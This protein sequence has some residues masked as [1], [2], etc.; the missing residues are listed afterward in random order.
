MDQKTPAT[1]LEF[2]TKS[3]LSNEPAAIHALEE[4]PR[5]MFVQ[6]LTAAFLG[7]HK[8]VLKAMVRNWPFPCLH[9]G[10]LRVQE[11]QYDNLEAMIDGLQILPAQFSSFSGP[12]LRI[13]DL[14]QDP[15]CRTTCSE[16]RTTFPYCFRSCVHSPHSIMK[17]E[18]AQHRV[19]CPGNVNSESEPQSSRKSMELLVDVSLDGTW[20]TARFLS[21]LRSKVEQSFGT[22]HLCC[23]YMQ[24]D[25]MPVREY[26][27]QFLD[28]GCIDHLEV[29][30][31][32]LNEAT[33]LLAQMTHLHR[34]SMS[35]IPFTSFMRRSFGTF[36]AHLV[37]MDTLQEIS[38]SYCHTHRLHK[39]LRCLPP[40]LDAL[41]LSFCGLS[42]RDI[43]ALSQSPAAPHLRL[44]SLCNNEISWEH[45]EAFQTLLA[46]VSGTLQHLEIDNCL[47]TDSTLTAVIPAL[48]H[49]SHL[50]VF[51]FTSNPITMRALTSLLQHLTNLTELKRVIYP[52]PVH[53][54]E[55][56][57]DPGSLNRLKLSEVQAQLKAMLQVV[58]RNDMHWTTSP[59]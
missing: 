37:Q 13:L 6:F 2:A 36:L 29:D 49:C 12:K 9:V 24:I 32:Y 45:S 42:N 22:L 38:L 27:L 23:R 34:L 33:P 31:I 3:L 28:M 20:R 55:R 35:H 30:E 52:V 21:L 53:C 17:I 18:E 50:R 5:D 11:S 15:G 14:R 43:T 44:L 51:S 4:L 56:L 8:K 25:K 16:I 39:L 57:H 54:Y 10:K 58:K 7:G 26:V 1:L 19:R 48:S 59:E 47:M 46:S 40:Q 41:Y